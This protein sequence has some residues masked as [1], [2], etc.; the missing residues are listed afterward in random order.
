ML[1]DQAELHAAY[2]LLRAHGY[3]QPAVAPMFAMGRDGV[4]SEVWP[5]GTPQSAI[6]QWTRWGELFRAALTWN[7]A[8]RG[9]A[10]GEGFVRSPTSLN[11]LH[12]AVPLDQES[13]ALS[14]MGNHDRAQQEAKTEPAG[15]FHPAFWVIAGA[16]AIGVIIELLRYRNDRKREKIASRGV[17]DRIE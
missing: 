13:A 9:Q 4:C 16:S 7:R 11:P 3:Q 15:Q 8:L 1:R 2:E 14:T 17:N 6:D 10:F 12:L 5:A